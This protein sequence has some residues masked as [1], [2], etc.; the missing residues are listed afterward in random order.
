MKEQLLVLIKSALAAGVLTQED[1]KAL[2]PAPERTL[3]IYTIIHN[4]GD[5]YVSYAGLSPDTVMRELAR[6]AAA[7]WDNRPFGQTGDRC[8]EGKSDDEILD[9]YFDNNDCEWYELHTKVVPLEDLLPAEREALL[10][11]ARLLEA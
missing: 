4:N 7:A 8:P 5:D 2:V 9:E 10:T 3:T 11:A 1:V 6:Y